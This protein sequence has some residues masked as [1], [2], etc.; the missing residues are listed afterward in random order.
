MNHLSRLLSILTTLKSKRIVTGPELAQ[1]FDVSLRTIYRDIRKL[2]ESG[3]PVI[4]I[5]GKGYSIL[6]GYT[7]AP[8]MFEENEVNAIVTAEKLIAKTNDESLILNFDQFLTKVKSVFKSSLKLKSEYLKDKM[9]VIQ[10]NNIE[11][12]SNSLSIIQSAIVNL[13]VIE[14]DYV[15]KKQDN[16]F[17]K[18]EPAAIYCFDEVWIVI[19]WCQLRNDYRTFRLDRIKSYKML[20]EK[21]KDRK[22]NLKEYF[23]SCPEIEYKL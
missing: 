17:R 11:R 15:D 8:V 18:I 6:D 19:A 13:S 12:R 4:T 7:V 21:F 22:F 14:I 9:M 3:V 2:E 10:N 1:K 23:M 20:N 16:T 5:E